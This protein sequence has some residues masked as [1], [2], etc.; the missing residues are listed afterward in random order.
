MPV[1][2]FSLWIVTFYKNNAVNPVV[3]EYGLQILAI[4]GGLLAAYRLSGYLFYRGN[5]RR[6]VFA[7]ALGMAICLTVLMDNASLGTRVLFAGW[8][9]GL[10]VLC[11]VL[12]SNFRSR[13]MNGETDAAE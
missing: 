10:G 13:P 8:A 6:A 5:P 2:F 1:V 4:S 12:V 3:W 7:C 9:I 11:W